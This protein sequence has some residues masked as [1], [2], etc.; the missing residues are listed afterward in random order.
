MKTQRPKSI[1]TIAHEVVTGKT[2]LDEVPSFRRK[3]VSNL[4]KIAKPEA[5]SMMAA[6]ETQ[7]HKDDV[8]SRER[9]K[10]ASR[11]YNPGKVSNVRSW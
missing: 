2:K 9:D 11:F 1:T 6:K 3:S 5:I 4:I 7:Q 10:F 8:A